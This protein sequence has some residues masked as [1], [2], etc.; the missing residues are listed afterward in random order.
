M[1]KSEILRLQSSRITQVGSKCHQ[2]LCLKEKDRGLATEESEVRAK[3]QMQPS[4]AGGG[5]EQ[6]FL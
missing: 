2:Q 6:L 5:K 1:I 3:E 4:D